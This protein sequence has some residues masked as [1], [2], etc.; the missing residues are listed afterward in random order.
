MVDLA[1]DIDRYRADSRRALNDALAGPLAAGFELASLPLTDQGR[2]AIPLEKRDV[3]ALARLQVDLDDEEVVLTVK[4]GAASERL[5]FEAYTPAGAALLLRRR[6]PQQAAA[7]EFTLSATR[8]GAAVPAAGLPGLI[9]VDALSGNL[10]HLL[11]VLS[12]EQQR[13]R[14]HLRA[15]AAA[16]TID[17]AKGGLL[18]RLGA[19]LGVPRFDSRMVFDAGVLSEIAPEREPDARYRPRLRLFRGALFPT[20]EEVVRRLR[21]VNPG[22]DLEERDN[23]FEVAVRIASVAPTAQAA[24]D[25]LAAAFERLRRSQLIDPAAPDA[26]RAVPKAQKAEEKALRRRLRDGFSAM[27]AVAAMAPP[28]ARALDRLLGFAGAVG[29]AGDIALVKAQDDAGG[30]LHELGL[31]AQIRTGQTF[32]RQLADRIQATDPAATGDFAAA[33]AAL[34]PVAGQP[35]EPQAIDLLRPLGFATARRLDG[36]NYYLS[37]LP[38][39]NLDIAGP[40]AV[41]RPPGA[42]TEAV[43]EAADL[44]PRSAE[45]LAEAL[46]AAREQAGLTATAVAGAQILAMLADLPAHEAAYRDRILPP[47]YSLADQTALQALWQGVPPEALAGLT[48]KGATAAGLRNGEEDDWD[49]VSALTFSLADQGVPA[50][51]VL[52]RQ[53]GDVV[54][55]ASSIPLPGLG[56]N[57][58]QRKALRLNWAAADLDTGRPTRAASDPAHGGGTRFP[59]RFEEP[60]VYAIVLTGYRRMGLTDPLEVRPWLPP[61]ETLDYPAYERM[62]NILA[63]ACPA[64]VEINTWPIRQRHVKLDPDAPPAALNLAAARSF[65][66]FRQPRFAVPQSPVPGES[67]A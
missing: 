7:V 60:G 4:R 38:I 35:G 61:G 56:P 47:R 28:L 19:E 57:L 12:L 48:V 25:Q 16:R 9:A 66:R 46:K 54:L 23:P 63:H 30:A 36:V 37:H 59:V 17:G 26:D 13:I 31:G 64:G 39:G 6:D 42:R 5:V 50:L 20:R 2:L 43:F 45:G 3:T 49:K 10:A 24:Q 27:P 21:E 65:R 40:G 55:A 1:P 62:M 18:D 33:V 14:R 11:M 44:A 67:D 32:L 15:L 53:N 34:K 51:A 41:E 22:F 8:G 52:V 29:F 58:T